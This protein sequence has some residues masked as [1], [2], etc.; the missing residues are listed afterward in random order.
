MVFAFRTAIH[1]SSPVTVHSSS[2]SASTTLA[3]TL[4]IGDYHRR[5]R[6]VCLSACLSTC[7]SIIPMS[8]EA[9]PL[10]FLDVL[11]SEQSVE[12][13][14]LGLRANFVD[15]VRSCFTYFFAGA[16]CCTRYTHLFTAVCVSFISMFLSETW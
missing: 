1:Q 10:M 2:S 8:L 13:P 14:Q 11:L 5:L 7:L 12:V 9:A 3:P 16:Q 4:I 6:L 15:C